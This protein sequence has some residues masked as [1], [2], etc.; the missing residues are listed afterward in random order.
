MVDVLTINAY[1]IS[2]DRGAGRTSSMSSSKEI[3][4]ITSSNLVRQEEKALKIQPPEEEDA[5]CMTLP[6]VE[7]GVD[8]ASPCRLLRRDPSGRTYHGHH[9]VA[10]LRDALADLRP[11]DLLLAVAQTRKGEA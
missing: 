7:E 4:S 5:P 1:F 11:S 8:R 2:V 9:G 10:P 3:R 6:A